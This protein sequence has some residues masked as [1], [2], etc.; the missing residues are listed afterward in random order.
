MKVRIFGAMAI[1]C[2]LSCLLPAGP[3]A[4]GPVTDYGNGCVLDDTDRAATIDSLRWR[5]SAEQH[6]AVFHDAPLGAVPTGLKDGWV[7]HT[8]A[9]EP[10]APS[11]WVGKNFYTGPDGGHVMN[12]VTAG[13]IESWPAD[14]Y[15][16]P[17]MTDNGPVW[18]LNYAPSPTPQV[19]DEIREVAPGVWL[20][21]SWWRGAIQ[22][23]PLLSFVLT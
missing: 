15:S 8:S 19:Y 18:A 16:V 5:C 17:G 13:G 9:V 11:L 22:D 4:A 21:Y 6:L 20:G 1:A 12:R 10:I 3:A 7:T 14:V 2:G 23:T